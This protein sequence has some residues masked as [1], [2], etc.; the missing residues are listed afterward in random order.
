[1]SSDADVVRRI[2][3]QRNAEAARWYAEGEI[4][5]LAAI[6]C[7]DGWQMPP[8]TPA[9][10]GRD[11]IRAYWQQAIQWGKFEFLLDAQQVDVSGAMAIE[12]GKYRL[13]FV[14]GPAAPPGLNSFEDWGNYLVYW[15][16]DADGQWRIAADAPVSERA[17]QQSQ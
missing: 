16:H 1:M 8:N 5:S 2:I 9:L 4:D 17:L 14:A 7:L 12:R 13:G 10:V 6:F 11:A 3:D 15:R